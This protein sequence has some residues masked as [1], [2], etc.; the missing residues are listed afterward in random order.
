MKPD[1]VYILIT[2][3]ITLCLHGGCSF[4]SSADSAKLSIP[5]EAVSEAIAKA[6]ELFRQRYDT[7]NLRE[8]VAALA[9]IR[10]PEDRN[11]EVEWKF[12]KY[13]YFLAR[14]TKDPLESEEM[15]TK[16]REAGKIAMRVEPNKPDGHF[17]YGANLGELARRSPVTVGIRSVDDIRQAMNKVIELEP[18]YQGA[19]AFDALAQ[20]ELATRL[21]GGDARKAVELLEKSLEFE[22]DNANIRARLAE[23]Y[24]AVKR[25]A[26]ARRQIDYLLQMEPHPEYVPEYNESVAKVKKLLQ[27]NF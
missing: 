17:W 1:K 23:A 14:Q 5:P 13:S 2:I 4:G 21:T 8:A 3:V 6:D 26:D 15:L 10:N 11:Y 22:K 19:S 12:A 20:V 9:A 24:L 27:T 25:D 16:G 18:G 7:N